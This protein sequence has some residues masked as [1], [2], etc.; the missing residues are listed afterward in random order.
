MIYQDSFIDP[1]PFV[2]HNQGLITRVQDRL[3][4]DK[5]YPNS[6][7]DPNWD[8]VNEIVQSL[9]ELLI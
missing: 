5:S 9:N 8:V 3:T 1:Y 4:Y 2:T 7:L 6:T